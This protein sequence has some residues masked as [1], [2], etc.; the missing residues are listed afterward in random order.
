MT[1]HL[2]MEYICSKCEA[3]YIPYNETIVCP[4][5]GNKEE[6]EE[7][8]ELIRGICNS[9]EYNINSTGRFDN[10]WAVM[11]ISDTIQSLF[12]DIFQFW[13]IHKMKEYSPE[14]RTKEFK[15]YLKETINNV[16]FGEEDYMKKYLEKIGA[17]IYEE[18]FNIRKYK[19]IVNDKNDKI[20]IEDK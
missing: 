14:N 6:L 11:D 7:Y 17:K 19:L 15:K 20:K 18:F 5:C 10:C 3:K 13:V 8:P 2:S 4:K 1:L 9:F 16:D 12:F